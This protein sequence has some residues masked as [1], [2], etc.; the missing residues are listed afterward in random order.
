MKTFFII[1]LVAI[2][3]FSGCKK[4]KTD[5]PSYTAEVTISGTKTNFTEMIYLTGES[6]TSVLIN[7]TGSE[8][9][10]KTISITLSNP[11]VG[12]IN[13]SFDNYAD[14]EIGSKSYTTKSGKFTITKKDESSITGTFTG[15]F[16]DE[17]S[18]EIEISGSFTAQKFSLTL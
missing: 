13:F 15:T 3:T 18:A 7:N 10:T 16:T 12:D 17:A 4:D 11:A 8:N 14:I 1:V 9:E 6:T 2:I 5:S